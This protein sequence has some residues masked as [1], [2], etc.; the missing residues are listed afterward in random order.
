LRG[1]AIGLTANTLRL[2]LAQQLNTLARVEPEHY[3]NFAYTKEQKTYKSVSCKKRNG[4][5]VPFRF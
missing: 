1:F 3:K 4:I 2:F 5:Q